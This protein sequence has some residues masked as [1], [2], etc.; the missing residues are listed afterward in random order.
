MGLMAQH[1]GEAR[2]LPNVGRHP[3][4]VSAARAFIALNALVWLA[5]G[6]IIAANAHPA[7]PDVP[8]LKAAMAVI[9]FAAAG[10]WAAVFIF[11]GKHSRLAYVIALAGFA[12]TAL[13]TIF[14]DFGLV[15]LA[16]VVI[17]IVPMVLLIRDRAWYAAG[18]PG[19][20][21]GDGTA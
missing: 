6:V 12:A 3:P 10:A 13:V 14:D 8:L 11:L 17:N 15:D 2:T 16:V 21:G 19:A 5:F 18:R 7:L 9:A 20:G 4:W 1:S